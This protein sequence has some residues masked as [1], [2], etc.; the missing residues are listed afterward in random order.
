M[1]A[2]IAPRDIKSD[3]A[4]AADYALFRVDLIFGQLSLPLF[5]FAPLTQKPKQ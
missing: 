3:A 2:E 5:R 1:P 4:G